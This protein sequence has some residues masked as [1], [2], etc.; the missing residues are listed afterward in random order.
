MGG[1]RK[2]LSLPLENL[3]ILR[4]L[5]IKIITLQSA[6]Q[7]KIL[8]KKQFQFVEQRAGVIAINGKSQI[9]KSNKQNN[10]MKVW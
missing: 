2:F 1:V 3:D 7:R 4:H 5:L 10:L 8:C 6:F 9:L